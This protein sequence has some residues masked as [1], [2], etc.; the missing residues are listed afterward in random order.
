M[1]KLLKISGL[2]FLVS[3]L[4]TGCT[5]DEADSREWKSIQSNWRGGLYRTLTV[6][7]ESGE[8]IQSWTGKFDID[9]SNDRTLFDIDG[10]RVIIKGGIIISEEETE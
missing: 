4:L 6:Y 9:N 1:T 8:K 5:L 3:T 10:K 2:A 7:S